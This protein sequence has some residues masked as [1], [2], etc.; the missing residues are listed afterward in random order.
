MAIK[1][2]NAENEVIEKRQWIFTRRNINRLAYEYDAEVT[3][4]E[5]DI[6]HAAIKDSRNRIIFCE[7]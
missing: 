1:I 7:G 4:F 5:P 2:I 3:K 6:K